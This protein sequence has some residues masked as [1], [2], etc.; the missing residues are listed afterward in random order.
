M[1]FI[2][3]FFLTIQLICYMTVYNVN[4]HPWP[5]LVMEHFTLLTEFKMLNPEGL[6]RLWNQD[7]KLNDW[8]LQHE[9]PMD[10]FVSYGIIAG[11]F[12]TFVTTLFVMRLFL[13]QKAKK[14][15][16]K[17]ID[18]MHWRGIIMSCLV[19]C[20]KVN[21]QAINA[22]HSVQALAITVINL[23]IPLMI[24]ISLILNKNKIVDQT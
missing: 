5:S 7:F 18:N 22:G 19:S 3:S 1:S 12:V 20:L 17:T 24:S 16:K 13:V 23:L 9:F 2:W 15:L 6:I 14:M 4:I 21:V 11:L 8:I 10:G